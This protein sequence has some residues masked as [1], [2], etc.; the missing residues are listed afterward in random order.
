MSETPPAG[1][2]PDPQDNTRQRYW[3]GNAW[4]EHTAP[5]QQAS[6]AP[7]QQPAYAQNNALGAQAPDPW[8]WQS[9]V[10]TVI[11]CLTTGFFGLLGIGGIVNASG[12]QQAAN[13]GDLPEAER[14]AKLARNFTIAT[15]VLGF[16]GLIALFALG[17]FGAMMDASSF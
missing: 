11:C 17:F 13:R 2:Y 14:K 5:G 9:I 16:V 8:M 7:A 10:T 15:L 1:W 6:S 3:D 12:S 4:T